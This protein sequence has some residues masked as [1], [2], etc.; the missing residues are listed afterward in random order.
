MTTLDWRAM[1]APARE[2]AVGVGVQLVLLTVLA[3]GVGLRPEGWAAATGYAVILAVLLTCALSRSRTRSLGPADWVTLARAE[4]VGGVTALVATAWVGKAVPVGLIVALATV[5]L[6]LDG[7][8][9]QVARRTGTVSALGARFDMETDAFLVLVLSVFAARSLGVWVL[10]IGAMRY[11]FVAASWAAPWLR[12]SLPPSFARK[13][14]AATQGVI[15]VVAIAGVT[16]R[17]V[18][19]GLVGAALAALVWSFGR[20]VRWLWRGRGAAGARG[21]TSP[22]VAV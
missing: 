8:D 22:G 14:V 12:A 21:R 5:A 18:A 13:T 2:P 1:R 4:L 3:A 20:D 19:A 15:L 11:V 10:A 17:P 9:G 7:V 6:V 16:S